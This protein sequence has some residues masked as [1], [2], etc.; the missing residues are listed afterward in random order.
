MQ[1]QFKLSH[2]ICI[3]LYTVRQTVEH[4]KKSCRKVKKFTYTDYNNI[5]T[6]HKYHS[7]P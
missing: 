2:D 6:Q 7:N 4:G 3:Y 1:S 5:K